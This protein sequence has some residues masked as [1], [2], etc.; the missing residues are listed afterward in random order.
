MRA[1]LHWG[2]K[3]AVADE[4]KMNVRATFCDLGGDVQEERVIFGGYEI[5][6]VGDYGCTVGNGNTVTM[7][8]IF[9]TCCAKG[10]EIDSVMKYGDAWVVLP[11]CGE[12]VGCSLTRCGQAVGGVLLNPVGHQTAVGFAPQRIGLA[13]VGAVTL[14]DARGYSFEGGPTQ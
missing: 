14:R 12:E 3:R 6:D 10:L 13:I 8:R 5:A 2:A 7:R 1:H 4:E 11:T 9:V